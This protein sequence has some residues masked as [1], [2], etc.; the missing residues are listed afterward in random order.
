MN[1]KEF[2][3]IVYAGLAQAAKTLGDPRR[4][5]IL[6]ML[7]QAPKSVEQLASETHMSV[8]AASHHLQLLKQ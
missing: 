5:E 7:L 8:A 2:K 3:T 6:D 4:L 1:A